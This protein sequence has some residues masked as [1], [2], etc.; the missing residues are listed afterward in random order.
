MIFASIALITL[1]VLF[2]FVSAIG[3]L[4][5]PEIYTRAHAVAKSETLGLLLV[6]GGLFFHPAI[7]LGSAVRLVLVLAF[8]L[9]AN[10]TAV[11]ALV[12]AARRA[13]VEPWKVPHRPGAEE[14]SW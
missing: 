6:L 9:I 8:A 13:G 12:R 10:P 5:L 2:M 7:D 4:R 11:H 1:G 14:E 3:L